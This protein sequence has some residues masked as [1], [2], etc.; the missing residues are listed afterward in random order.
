MDWRSA[1]QTLFTRLIALQFVVVTVT[2]FGR[3]GMLFYATKIDGDHNGTLG[4]HLPEFVGYVLVLIRHA[5]KMLHALVYSG[6][7]FI[8]VALAS[9]LGVQ[10]IYFQDPGFP[11]TRPGSELDDDVAFSVPTTSEALHDTPDRV[12]MKLLRYVFF[13]VNWSDLVDTQQKLDHLVRQGYA[14]N[15]WPSPADL[16]V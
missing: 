14:F 7:I 3:W 6:P 10:W 5:D 15:S 9:I 1:I 13:S 16:R 12:A 2:R 8:E 4:I 11:S